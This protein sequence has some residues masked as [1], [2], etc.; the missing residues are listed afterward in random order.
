MRYNNLR[1][2]IAR[3]RAFHLGMA[4]IVSLSPGVAQTTNFSFIDGQTPPPQAGTAQRAT[5]TLSLKDALALAE[6]NDPGIL[7]ALSDAASAREDR[8]QARAALYPSLSGRSEYLGTQGNGKLA[9]KPIRHQR[10]CPCLSGMGHRAP[11]PLT[12]HFQAHRRPA[13]RLPEA[14]ARAKVGNCAPGPGSHGHENLL[15]SYRRSAQ[16]CHCSTRLL[17]RPSV[18][19]PSARNLER[20]GEV[21]HSDVVKSELFSRIRSTGASKK[22]N[23]AWKARVWILPFCCIRDFNENFTIVDDLDRRPGS[24]APSGCRGH[25][26]DAKIRPWRRRCRLCVPRVWMSPS[27]DRL[28][29]PTLTVDAVYGIEANASALCTA[30]LRPYKEVGPRAQSRLL[31]HRQS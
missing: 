9:Y 12:R 10:R 17:I 20:G 2:G 5:V 21:A 22:R 26:G 11:G 14:L 7:A 16:I 13:G 8:N 23:S 6:K 28:T 24:A 25:G 29:L 4:L 31:H 15:R 18:C 30:R 19:S 27:R 1:T 3:P